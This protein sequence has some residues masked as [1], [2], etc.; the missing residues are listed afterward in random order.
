MRAVATVFFVLAPLFAQVLAGTTSSFNPGGPINTSIGPSVT[1]TTSCHS[2]HSAQEGTGTPLSFNPGGP[3]I[4]SMGSP[5]MTPTS[6]HTHHS[7]SQ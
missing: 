1:D 5:T 2:H 7:K 6:R 4:T 3:I